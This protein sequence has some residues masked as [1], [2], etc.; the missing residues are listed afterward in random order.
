MRQLTAAATIAAAGILVAACGG[1]NGGNTASSSSSASSTTT[2]TAAKA[3]VAPAALAGLLLPLPDID[4]ALGV[5]GTKVD[6][7]FDA[8]QPDQS[9]TAFAPGYKFPPECVFATDS[10][11]VT[12][13]DGSGSTA[14]K[15][16]HDVAPQQPGSN[17]P[18]PDA[19]QFVVLFAS[20]DQ[21]NAFYNTSAQRWPACA[22][23]QDTAPGD[24][25]TPDIQW[26]VGPVSNANGI[27]TTTAVVSASKNG[28]SLGTQNCQRALTVRNNVVIDVAACL[29]DA[30]N[31]G[32]NIA[33]QIAGKVDKQ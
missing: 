12:V 20:A 33:N 17:D 25:N 10:G 19:T 8:L 1:S 29:K 13:Y 9:S 7:P 24:A 32:V 31:V 18:P 11:V 26:K 5:T 21:A 3:P 27:L 28:Q 6:K 2:T 30:G 16:E 14:A 4:T 15:G 23:R 22:N